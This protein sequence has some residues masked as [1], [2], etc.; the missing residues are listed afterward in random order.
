MVFPADKEAKEMIVEIG[1]RMYEKG[2]VAS[3]DG[4]ISLKVSDN[5]IW[6]TPT[7]ISKGFMKPEMMVKL[8]LDGN[9]IEGECKPSS[10]IKMHL[11]VYKE[12]KKV[13]SVTHA[14][15]MYAT[16]CAI[17]G[18]PLDKPVLIEAALQLGVIPVARY[19]KP[20]TDEVGNSVAPFCKNFNGVLLSNHGAL[21]W[22]EDVYQSYYRLEVMEYYAKVILELEKL[23]MGRSLSE[24]QLR[25]LENIKLS[26]GITSGP[27]HKGSIET[28]NDKDII[29]KMMETGKVW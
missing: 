19:A 17:A 29:P 28:L 16:I 9:I 20:G 14:H 18:I 2:F 3:N 13:N 26:M 5:Y 25:D 8:D 22:G 23:Q 1:R 12:N 4:N 15:P 10:E 11:K 21:T 7:G 6:A 24:K 27:L